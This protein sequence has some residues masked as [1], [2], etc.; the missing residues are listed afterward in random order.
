MPPEND[1][2]HTTSREHYAGC[3]DTV[4]KRSLSKE[5]YRMRNLKDNP[6]RLGGLW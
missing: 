1:H 4:W 6:D 2:Q 5:E 3:K